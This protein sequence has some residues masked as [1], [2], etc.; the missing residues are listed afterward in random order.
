MVIRCAQLP[1][2]RA[3][4]ELESGTPQSPGRLDPGSR[5]VSFVAA[6]GGWEPLPNLGFHRTIVRGGALSDPLPNT[7]I[8]IPDRDDGLLPQCRHM[9]GSLRVAGQ[10]AANVRP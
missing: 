10:A 4:R 9:Q 7:G 3:I 2:Q 5:Q 6:D 8:Q 1:G